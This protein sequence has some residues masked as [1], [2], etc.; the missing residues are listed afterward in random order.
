MNKM[1]EQ[2]TITLSR[3]GLCPQEA[4][5]QAAVV[6]FAGDRDLPRAIHLEGLVGSFEQENPSVRYSSSVPPSL[7][8]M[9]ALSSS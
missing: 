9:R 7:G 2:G 5:I 3:C 8:R 4:A 6:T 1:L